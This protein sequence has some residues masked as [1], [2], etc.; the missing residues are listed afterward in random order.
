MSSGR[1]AVMCALLASATRQ[2][3]VSAVVDLPDA[4][5][6][7]SLESVGADLHRILWVRPPSLRTSLKCTDLILAAGG[8]GL[9]VLDL[10]ETG[11]YRF[12]LHVWPRLVRIAKQTQT[13]TVVLARQEVVGSFAALRITLMHRRT[14][15]EAGECLLEGLTTHVGVARN[16]NGTLPAQSIRLDAWC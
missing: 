3:E 13:A 15:W 4:L 8:F 10:S 5:H 11:T 14:L 9:V 6:P 2:A 12:P 1:T 7:E 16:K